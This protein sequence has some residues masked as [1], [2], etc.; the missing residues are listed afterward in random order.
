MQKLSNATLKS[1]EKIALI[2]NFS[3]MLNAGI[4]ILEIVDSLLE[5][6]K[7]NVKK[8]L[9]VLKDDLG[10]GQPVHVS[11][12][13]FPKIFNKVTVNI[14]K[15]SEETG[16]LGTT[17]NDLK[18]NIQKEMEF[19]DKVKTALVYPIFIFGVFFA[20]LLFILTFVIPKVADVFNHL[21]IPLP[22]PTRI[23]VAISNAITGYPLI[24]VSGAIIIATL[25]V[26]VFRAERT[27]I[28]DIIFSLPVFSEIIKQIDLT[29]FSRS[30]YLLLY[31][32]LPI[33]DSLELTRDV[34]I[35]RRMLNIIKNSREMM[36]SGKT[37]SKG[38]RAS[39]GYVPTLMIK[40]VEAG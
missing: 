29:K 39:K 12:A 7:G 4:P 36:L 32:G 23:L 18:A 35:K 6:T 3:T 21:R 16:T 33:T 11:F 24:V 37:L 9:D 27:R 2:G 30:M 5:D 1:T 8:V 26:L 28:L 14:I 13:K 25:I 20:V 31:S 17:L 19:N 34:V 10:Q 22:L 40:L 38:L 15:A